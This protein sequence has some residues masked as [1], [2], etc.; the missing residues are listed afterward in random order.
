MHKHTQ[1]CHHEDYREPQKP[2]VYFPVNLFFESGFLFSYFALFRLLAK[3]LFH[4]AQL[5][6][7]SS[8]QRSEQQMWS[9]SIQ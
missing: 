6:L 2:E 8:L 9:Q 4:Q 7:R 3:P 5:R 1:S